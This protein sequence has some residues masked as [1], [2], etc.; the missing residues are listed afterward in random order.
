LFKK[1]DSPI[2]VRPQQLAAPARKG[3]T[4]VEWGGDRSEIR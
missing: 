3:F 2:E 1:L 4:V